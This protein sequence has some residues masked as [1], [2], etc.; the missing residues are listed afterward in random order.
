M[1]ALG[2][3]DLVV[4]AFPAG[5]PPDSFLAAL[6]RVERREAV[7]ILDALVVI[8]SADGSVERVELADIAG[9]GD[10]AAEIAARRT[11]GLVGL[12]DVEEIAGVMDRDSTVLALLVENVWAREVAEE[13]RRHDGRLLATVRIPYEQI[14]EV[15]AELAATDAARR[16]A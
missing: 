12:D 13:A 5:Q 3:V 14:A 9:L 10:V 6:E 1:T 2:P 15:E 16:A 8:K 4:L 7:R 11:L